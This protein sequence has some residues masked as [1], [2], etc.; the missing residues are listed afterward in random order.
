MSEPGKVRKILVP[1]DGSMASRQAIELALVEARARDG[2]LVLLHVLSFPRDLM[3]LDK[4]PWPRDWPG[5]V[6]EQ[7]EDY[8]LGVQLELGGKIHTRTRVEAGDP[9]RTIVDVARQEEADMIVMATHGR[10]VPTRWLLGGVA[11]K[12][13]YLASC[14][15]LLV[16]IGRRDPMEAS[17]DNFS[18]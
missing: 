5:L 14:P 16:P 3:W 12:V 6:R 13:A 7:A 4:L 9:G 10:T 2:E 11:R 8:L 18:F 15:V 1:L 17:F